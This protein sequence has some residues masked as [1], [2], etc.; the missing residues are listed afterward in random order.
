MCSKSTP[1]SPSGNVDRFPAGETTDA[2]ARLGK[3]A[4]GDEALDSATANVQVLGDFGDG[5]QWRGD[6]LL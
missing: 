3:L 6:F 5:P 2:H 1:F 4:T